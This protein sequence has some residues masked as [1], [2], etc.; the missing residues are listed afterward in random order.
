MTRL[1]LDYFRRK[2]LILA[3]G[4]LFQF[5]MGF[6]AVASLDKNGHSPVSTFEFQI[7]LF[8]G[9][10][11]LSFDLQRGIARTV[12]SLPLTNRQIG[13]AWWLAT[14]AIPAV[15]LAALLFGGAATAHLVKPHEAFSTDWLTMTSIIVLLWLGTGFAFIFNTSATGWYGGWWNRARNILFGAVWGVMIGGGIWI[16]GDMSNSPVKSAGF[17]VIG[18]ALTAL[19]WFRAEQFALGRASFRLGT[20]T[21]GGKRASVHKPGGYGGIPLLISGTFVP[22]FMMGVAMLTL[23][24]LIMS[25]QGHLKSWRQAVELLNGMGFFP[26]WFIIFFMLVPVFMQLRYLRSLPISTTRLAA[27]MILMVV[28]PLVALGAVSATVTGLTIGMPAAATVVKSYA[29]TLA[30]ATLTVSFLVWQGTGTPAFLLMLFVM[31]TAQSVPLWL[32]VFFHRSEMPASLAGAIAVTYIL[33]SFLLTRWML[34]RSSQA[35]RV[36]QNPFNTSAWGGGWR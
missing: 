33:V 14:V 7:A 23:M 35:Y 1:M 11:L 26:F 31:I 16:F 10:L 15:A 18:T 27:V 30:P 24:P 9:A 12:A 17:F 21:A 5:V 13:R 28:L 19:G 3:A 6:A 36:Q 2:W 25:L 29:L 34:L 32:A 22:A 20:Q 8:M 4:A